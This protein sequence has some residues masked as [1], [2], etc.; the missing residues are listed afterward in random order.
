MQTFLPDSDFRRSALLL[1]R[2]RLGKQR[3]EALQV[4]R[5]LTVPGYGWRRHP[6][7]RMW[8]GYEE[9]L[10]RYGLEICRVWRERG[11]QDS[12]AAS[13]IAGYAA[14]RPGASVRD[15]PALAEAGELPPWLGDEAF[16]RSHR[17]ALV[18][19][20]RETY[21]DVFPDVP[22]DL[23]YVW[24]SSDRAGATA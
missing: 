17:S 3:V 11:H 24:P 5:G 15:Q 21:A 22:D 12:C 20:D 18:R 7:V 19:K 23:P 13:L 9:A 8:S 10:V 1:D 14:D 16:H 4:L 2:R 6:A